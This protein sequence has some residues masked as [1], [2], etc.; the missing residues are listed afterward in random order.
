MPV[1]SRVAVEFAS[2]G[3]DRVVRDERRVENAISQTAKNAMKSEGTVARWMDR[4]KSALAAIGATS[5]A[6]MAG[7]IALSPSLSAAMDDIRLNFSMLA[8]EIG[9]T[10]APA[11]EYLAG[12]VEDLTGWFEGLPEPVQ[13]AISVITGAAL[14]IGILAGAAAVGIWGLSQLSLGFTVLKDAAAGLTLTT[15]AGSLTT[16]GLAIAGIAGVLVGGVVVWLMWKAGV[17][18]A[19]E[20]AGA[21]VGQ[22]VYNAG[23]MFS[24]FLDKVQGYLSLAALYAAK[25]GLEF[26][27]N[28]V[29]NALAR[30]PLIGDTFAGVADSI[31][32]ALS[33]VNDEIATTTERLSH[34]L[35]EGTVTYS[36]DYAFKHPVSEA[37]AG[38]D[39]AFFED[40]LGWGQTGA[41]DDSI[42]R[43][44]ELV[45]S[46]DT[47]NQT[48]S[49]GTA[50]TAAAFADAMSTM[51]TAVSTTAQ[52]VTTSTGAIHTTTVSTF[53][54]LIARSH[55]WG[56]DLMGEFIAGLNSRYGDLQRTLSAIN[57]MIESALSYDIPANDRAAYRWGGDLVQHFS[58]GMDSLAATL[59]IPTPSPAP[60]GVS[61]STS[62]T[63]N[64]TIAPGAVQVNG[65]QAKDFDE[66]K[67]AQ[68]VRD[69][70]GS[71]LRGRG[72]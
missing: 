46:L 40:L 58:A 50:G 41:A 60:A 39:S 5:A 15:A 27:A 51:D 36:S 18:Q 45:A 12:K 43:M 64:I 24:N 2:M 19:I 8:M 59:T 57:T 69:E 1:V 11:F 63:V 65:A 6:A 35:G 68:Y 23:V 62:Q 25:Y 28:F 61:T 34:G 71:A 20:E 55:G 29:E 32:S 53:S 70:V 4:H 10:W 31:R 14:G 47:L 56:S 26:S 33:T 21:R 37:I 17:I 42:Q 16:L 67:I 38:V 54:D 9:E 48:A 72:R 44:E 52:N 22:F 49:T 13:G 7:I 3:A 66:R 30:L